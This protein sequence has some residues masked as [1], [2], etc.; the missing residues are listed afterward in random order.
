MVKK[1]LTVLTLLMVVFVVVACAK[2]EYTVT[3]DSN[4]GSAVTA[5]VVKEGSTVASPTDPTKED[6]I[7]AG[8][9]PVAAL[10]G[11]AYQFSTPVTANITL[12]AKWEVDTATAQYVRFVDHRQNTTNLIVADSTGKVAKPANPTRD[13][14]RFGGWYSSKRGL[15]WNDTQEFDFTQVI[16]E[17]GK[18]VYAYWEPV[19][20]KTQSWS[21]DETYFS[22]LSS[23]TTY[24]M[25]PLTYQYGDE[26][27]LVQSLSTPLYS[28]E[29]DWG[30]A[31]EDG[32]AEYPGDFSKFGVGEGMYGIDLLKNHYILVGA[33]AY[34]KDEN[35]HD[36]VDSETGEWDQNAAVNFLDDKWVVEI[37]SDLKFED[38][39]PITADD[40]VYTYKQYIDPVQNNL[41]GSTYFPTADRRNGYKILN[42]RS[43][44]LQEAEEGFYTGVGTDGNIPFSDVG[45]KAIDTYKIELTFETAVSQ[46]SAFGLMNNIYLVHEDTYEASLD[47]ARENSSYGTALYPYVSYGGYI[48]KTW[49][50]NAKLVFNKNYDYVLKHTINYKSISYQFTPDVDSNMELFAQGKL[51]A[52]GLTGEYA[53]EY[54]EWANNYPTYRGYPFSFDINMTDAL[55]DSRPA[56]PIMK[57]INFRRAI[58]FGFERQ[59][60]AN[61]L[62]APNTASILIW[63]IQGKQFNGDEYWYKDT[64]EHAEVLE[65]LG[66][67]PDTVGYDG[68]KAKQYFDDAYDAWVLAGNSGAI[69]INFIGFNDPLYISY[70]NYLV[71]H[72]EELFNGT[73]PERINITYEPLDDTVLFERQDNRKFDWTFDT[74]GWDRA[75]ATYVYMPLKGLYYDWLFGPGSGM[76]EIDAIE[77]LAEATVYKPLDLRNTLAF[78]ESTKYVPEGDEETPSGF[79]DASTSEGTLIELYDLLVEN[80]GYFDGLALDLFIYI[81]Y[82]EF[83]WAKDEEPYPGAVDDLTRMTAAFEYVI[84]DFVTLVPVGSRTSVTAYAMNVKIE[85]PLYSYELG[86]GS[87]RY[88]YLTTDPD[89]IA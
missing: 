79:W 63:P 46:T 86:W 23:T 31:I 85:W 21:D 20:S 75:D 22:T 76:N 53:S 47:D 87:A 71:Q 89:F 64:P 49:D 18:T 78:L 65:L 14:Y 16:P 35:G 10:T 3:F 57:D 77:G 50:E 30:K 38:G 82:D 62:F 34:P 68:N 67:N 54:A 45:F 24:V 2:K 48:I 12:Y 27:A 8:W 4:G 11:D 9:Y 80:E 52:V 61:T 69:Q 36:L 84:L 44:F 19:N 88:R 70:A 26:L 74:G 17:G 42:A 51:S 55:D 81:L 7:F 83:V 60:F 66:I 5:V 39:T 59:E 58:L 56:N 29:V 6:Y 25:N 13:G 43:Y 72:F 73:G 15:T 40:Y 32:I 33:A 37:R 1:I 28:Q 41:R